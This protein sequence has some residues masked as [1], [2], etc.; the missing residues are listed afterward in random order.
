M[1]L[2]EDKTE[3]QGLA[4]CH[5]ASEGWGLKSAPGRLAPK[6]ALAHCQSSCSLPAVQAGMGER[7]G[8]R[9]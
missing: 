2:P 6:A 4:Q 8:S 3:V 7:Q 9:G 1:T 5:P